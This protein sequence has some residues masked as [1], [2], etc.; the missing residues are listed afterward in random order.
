MRIR[1]ILALGTALTASTAAA[2][3]QEAD[4][5]EGAREVVII[6]EDRV[7]LLEREPSDTVFGLGKSLMETPRSATLVND[8]TVERYGIEEVDDLIA[9]S[10]GT[11]TASFYGVRGAVN[12]RGTLAESYFRGFKRIEN[13]GT[14]STPLGA[15]SQVDIVR[16]PPTP[17][18]GPGKVGGLINIIPKTA[19]A[20]GPNFI[21]K[22]SGQGEVTLG[23]YDKFNGAFQIGA[24]VSLGNVEG[25]VFGYVEREDSGSYY[26]GINPEHW[27]AQVSAEF[28]LSDT[29]SI[30]MGGMFYDAKGYVQSPGWNR[31]TQQLVDDQMYFTGQDTTVVD[32]DGNGRITPNEAGGSF[33]TGY[34]GFPPSVDDRYSL[35]TGVGLAKLDPRD[36][37]ISERDFSDTTTN[38]FYFDAVK[39]LGKNEL[40]FQ[41]FYDDLENKR[42]VSYGFPAHYDSYAVEGR[43]HYDFSLG[44]EDSFWTSNASVGASSRYQSAKRKESY[45]SGYIVLD[46][47]DLT[48]GA[49]ANDIFDDPFSDE[50]G[51][52]GA[53]WDIDVDSDWRDTGVFALADTTFGGVVN[54]LLG[55]RYDWYKGNSID[56][57]AVCY[58]AAGV[59]FE[60]E[61]E[62]FSYSASLSVNTPVGLFPY[63]TYA[64]SAAIEV[65][66]AGD[67]AGSLLSNGQW[68]SDSKLTEGGVKFDFLNGTLLGSLS[69]YDQSRTRLSL[70]NNVVATT[71]KGVELETRWLA[72]DN[73]SFTFAGNTQETTVEGPDAS[74][75]YVPARV[76]GLPLEDAYGGSFAVYNFSTSPVG[77]PGDYEQKSIP[78]TVLSLF[79]SYVSDPYE[80]GQIGVTAGVVSVSETSGRLVDAVVFPSYELA[81]LGLFYGYDGYELSL[82]IDNVFDELYFQPVADV[83][84]DMA[85][86]PGRGR[87][88]RV[89][90]KKSF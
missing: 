89:T 67:V 15:T 4:K 60:A 51:G 18:Y 75:T 84:A 31:L 69:A 27:L 14:Y 82:N 19:R 68:L 88:F 37:F 77:W 41:V 9:I 63:A 90:L 80:W 13:R 32:L 56:N 43:V 28:D 16:G 12:I 21:S 76:V 26:R 7:G 45:N 81:N 22:V 86:L 36:I 50:P 73:L 59:D 29:L 53:T 11:F 87:E 24:P 79:G 66:Q 8:T 65:G 30:A 44:S 35:D 33:V 25:G 48:V 85:V 17:A 10:P 34:F 71:S 6:R 54:L 70:M 42:F 52:I 55:A 74:F 20:N 46:R 62:K 57:G 1:A 5:E 40:K 64:E 61:D 3:G 83:Y 47:R 2:W 38:T 39:K 49:T 78:Q 58:C 23:S 72:T